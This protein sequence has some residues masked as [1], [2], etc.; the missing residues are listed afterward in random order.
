MVSL[1][2]SE[3]TLGDSDEDVPEVD[4]S[5]GCSEMCNFLEGGR[6]GDENFLD[7]EVLVI[8]GDSMDSC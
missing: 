8:L 2:S 3:D 4:I 5:S 6:S 7:N 1:H